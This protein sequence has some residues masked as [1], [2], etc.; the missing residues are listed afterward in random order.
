MNLNTVFVLPDVQ[1]VVNKISSVCDIDGQNI[2]E[3]KCI[4]Q[5]RSKD[6]FVNDWVNVEV[7]DI[8]EDE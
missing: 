3:I 5:R 1:T 7:N 6:I 2:N 4:R 8:E